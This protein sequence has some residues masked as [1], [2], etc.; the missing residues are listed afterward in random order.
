MASLGLVGTLLQKASP[1]MDANVAG[2]VALVPFGLA[3]MIW[4][5]K[6]NFFDRRVLRTY[7]PNGTFA[8]YA[9]AAPGIIFWCIVGA[10]IVLTFL[11][12]AAFFGAVGG[13]KS[14]DLRPGEVLRI[15]L[16]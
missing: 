13:G 16:K 2:A 14:V 15:N 1:D 10:V 4:A 11:I 12:I 7:G 8:T 3:W 5:A 6:T 9:L